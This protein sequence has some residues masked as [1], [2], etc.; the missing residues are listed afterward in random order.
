MGTNEY[1]G[2]EDTRLPWEKGRIQ[3]TFVK[4]Y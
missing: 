2:K 1:R 4:K 3:K